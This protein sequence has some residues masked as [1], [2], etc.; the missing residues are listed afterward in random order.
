MEYGIQE[1]K[2]TQAQEF[3][4]GKE[5]YNKVIDAWTHINND[6]SEI[7]MKEMKE[8]DQGFNA[9]YMMLDSGARGSK[10]QISQLSG[11]SCCQYTS[12]SNLREELRP[13]AIP[14]PRKAC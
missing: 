6:L 10:G 7:L 8:A 1:K 14:L 4:I 11:R 3:I 5:R 9:V 12:A 2:K 13:S